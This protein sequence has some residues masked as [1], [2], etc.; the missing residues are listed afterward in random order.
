MNSIG[1]VIEEIE[2]ANNHKICSSTTQIQQMLGKN[3]TITNFLTIK[4]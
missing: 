4:F 1:P 2:K 3:K